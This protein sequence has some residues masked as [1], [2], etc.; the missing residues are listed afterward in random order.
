MIGGPAVV[1]IG[2]PNTIAGGLDA[3]DKL[4]GS[5]DRYRQFFGDVVHPARWMPGDDLHRLQP[6][7]WQVEIGPKP[8]INGVP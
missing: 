4:A 8:S 7:Q 3:V 1:G 6:T 5:T 2:A